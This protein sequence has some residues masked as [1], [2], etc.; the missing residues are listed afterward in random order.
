MPSRDCAQ[1]LAERRQRAVD[2]VLSGHS[3]AEAARIEGTTVRSVRRWL[4]AFRERGNEGLAARPA[5]GR[6]PKLDPEQEARL[7]RLL[8]HGPAANGCRCR[9]WEGWE[10][11]EVIAREFRISYHADSIDDLLKRIAGQCIRQFNEELVSAT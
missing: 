11:A 1:Q 2:L 5:T 8:E 3:A 4:R 10:I 6:P 7:I 9:E